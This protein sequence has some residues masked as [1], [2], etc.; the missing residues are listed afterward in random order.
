M[1]KLSTKALL[2]TVLT[3]LIVTT[4]SAMAE[5]QWQHNH[6]RR[7]EV[8]HRLNHQ[9]QRIHR[10][11]REGEMNRQQA[12]QLHT[13]DHQIRQEERDMARQNGGHITKQEQR[14]LNQQEN[15]VSHQIG[16]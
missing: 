9:D 3:G 6:P 5:T 2:A 4:T 7:V 14:T 1:S 15:A 11:V 16:Q 13:E 10:E 12:R 8:N